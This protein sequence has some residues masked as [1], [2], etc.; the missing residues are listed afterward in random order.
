MQGQDTLFIEHELTKI[1]S[2]IDK[3]LYQ[4]SLL[5]AMFLYLRLLSHRY[6]VFRRLVVSF[7]LNRSDD[8]NSL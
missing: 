6:F 2:R 8:L 3:L 7:R 4:L 5:E 1:F